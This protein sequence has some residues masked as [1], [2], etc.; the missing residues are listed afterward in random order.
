MSRN[1]RRS[2]GPPLTNSTSA[3]E[4]TTAASRPSASPRRSGSD[5]STVTFL[6]LPRFS[7]AAATWTLRSSSPESGS[8]VPTTRNTPSPNATSWSSRAPRKDR[9]VSR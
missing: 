8:S 7:K 1:R 5:P 2:D 3:G 6:R 9:N 4:K